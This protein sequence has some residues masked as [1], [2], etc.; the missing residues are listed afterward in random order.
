MPEDWYSSVEGEK[1]AAILC[2]MLTRR[3]F[4]CT[5]MLGADMIHIHVAAVASS[6]SC[7]ANT[8][9]VSSSY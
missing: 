1:Q 3:F 2:A 5:K 7:L 9:A 6:R 8:M 4:N